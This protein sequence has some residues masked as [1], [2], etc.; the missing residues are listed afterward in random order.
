MSPHCLPRAAAGQVIRLGTGALLGAGGHGS[1]WRLWQLRQVP[2]RKLRQ[3]LTWSC[4]PVTLASLRQRGSLWDLRPLPRY[5]SFFFF[6][7]GMSISEN[8]FSSA[9]VTSR[10]CTLGSWQG[11]ALTPHCLFF[12]SA[13]PP[14][15]KNHIHY[16]Y[17]PFR[18]IFQC[19]LR[20]R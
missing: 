17:F 6:L 10:G 14:S 16:F 20:K 3:N 4:H 8:G 5:C 1:S 11:L 7:T 9:K 2:R 12:S 18:F 19:A 13:P 15:F